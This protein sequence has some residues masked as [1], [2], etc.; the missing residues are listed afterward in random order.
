MRPMLR[1]STLALLC[2]SCSVL[3]A[4]DAGPEVESETSEVTALVPP[5][6]APL[7]DKDLAAL[8]VFAD[9]AAPGCSGDACL[10]SCGSQSPSCPVDSQCDTD[11]GVCRRTACTGDA[12]CSSATYCNP[13]SG[14]CELPTCAA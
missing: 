4:C 14:R 7:C 3:L 13:A 11:S 6:Q 2:V 10:P 5:S 1:L 12:Q 9:Y 8:R